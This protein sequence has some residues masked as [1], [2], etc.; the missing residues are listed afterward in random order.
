MSAARRGS[1]VRKAAPRKSS[2]SVRARRGGTRL[3]TLSIVA[4]AVILSGAACLYLYHDHSRFSAGRPS[5]VFARLFPTEHFRASQVR[6]NADLVELLKEEVGVR[7]QDVNERRVELDDRRGA[8]EK[9]HWRISWRRG[10]SL[11]ELALRVESLATEDGFKLRSRRIESRQWGDYLYLELSVHDRVSHSLLVTHERRRL[12]PEQIV[13]APRVEQD[14][15]YRAAIVIDDVGYDLD[16]L[17]QFLRIEEPL[18]YSVLP[19][20]S[21]SVLSAE[22]THAAGREVLVHM[23]M[24]PRNYPEEDPGPGAIL[25]SMDPEDA[26]AATLNA[27]EAIPHAIGLNNHMG[28]RVTTDPVLTG[29]VIRTLK[30]KGIFFLDSRTTASS[31]A[32]DMARRLGLRSAARKVFLDDVFDPYYIGMMLDELFATARR[33]GSAIAIGH[34]NHATLEAL[35]ANLWKADKYGVRLCPVGE[36]VE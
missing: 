2:V 23:P 16:L 14:H 1:A 9:L 4:A 11:E 25:R 28:S 19:F 24:E 17:H 33:D 8:Y 26:R 30:E 10:A 36:L 29:M 27:L 18:A 22:A 35:R 7:E 12:E 13:G 3:A 20:L 21:E 31:V 5:N 34:L 32:Y 6:L 15:P